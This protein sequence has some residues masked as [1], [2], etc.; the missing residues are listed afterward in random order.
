MK[1]GGKIIKWGRGDYQR[2]KKLNRPRNV[3][4]GSFKTLR[5]GRTSSFRESYT[6][7][8]NEANRQTGKL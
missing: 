7:S 4:E 6:L 8:Y 1:A 3:F 5:R 2:E